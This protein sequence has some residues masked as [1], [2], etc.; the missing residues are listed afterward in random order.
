[1]IQKINISETVDL[2]PAPFRAK[3]VAR[4]SGRVSLRGRYHDA[5][6]TGCRL[7]RLDRPIHDPDVSALAFRLGVGTMDPPIKSAGEVR[8]FGSIET[9]ITKKHEMF[10]WACP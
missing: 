2:I 8:R 1:M 7:G 6:P 4:L 10:I 3:T 5:A 9:V